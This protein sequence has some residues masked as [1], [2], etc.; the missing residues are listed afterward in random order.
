M[1]VTSWSIWFPC[2]RPCFTTGTGSSWWWTRATATAPPKHGWAKPASPSYGPPTATKNP[3]PGRVLLRAVRQTIESVTDTIKDQH[4]PDRPGG[5]TPAVL[6]VH[7][8][9][10]DSAP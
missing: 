9:A 4:G 10:T 6:A 8:P 7:T 3:G 1:N 5:A 2:S